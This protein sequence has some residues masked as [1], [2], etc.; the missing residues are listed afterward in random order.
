MSEPVSVSQHCHGLDAALCA[1]IVG[2]E[3]KGIAIHRLRVSAQHAC[4]PSDR[5][6]TSVADQGCAPEVVNLAASTSDGEKSG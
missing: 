1:A 2:E 6:T 5:N 3:V 4:R